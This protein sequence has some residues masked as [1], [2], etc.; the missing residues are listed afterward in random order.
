MSVLLDATSQPQ[1]RMR[2]LVVVAGH[3]AD[4]RSRV[5]LPLASLGFDVISAVDGLD[6]LDAVLSHGP[7]AIVADL[8]MP[9]LDGLGLCRAL[10]AL[11]GSMRLPIIVYTAT[12]RCD[13]RLRDAG[14]LHRA[15]II[16]TARG[17]TVV[18][19]RLRKMIGVAG[20]AAAA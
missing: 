20:G 7:D 15:Q 17:I 14:A 11:R 4:Q 19:E 9:I 1:S 12:D 16:G 6:A 8:D 5:G 3:G 18:G 10:R 2:P 13:P